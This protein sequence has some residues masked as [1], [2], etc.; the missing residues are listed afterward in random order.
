[1]KPMGMYSR[2]SDETFGMMMAVLGFFCSRKS[3]GVA[4]CL[5]VSA[6]LLARRHA[7]HLATHSITSGIERMTVGST[8]LSQRHQRPSP[9]MYSFEPV[10]RL[11]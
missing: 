8:S 11:M 2:R 4:A 7:R 1:M 3:V 6:D 10:R 5:R 9:W